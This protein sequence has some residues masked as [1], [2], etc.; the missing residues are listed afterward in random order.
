MRKA[1]F[2]TLALAAISLDAAA[3]DT[4]VVR[5]LVVDSPIGA[6]SLGTM[7]VTA[8]G[9][10]GDS[11]GY[12]ADIASP[13]NP[14]DVALCVL[15]ERRTAFAPSC[16]ANESRD[17]ATIIEAGSGASGGATQCGGF[18]LK[19]ERYEEVSLLLTESPCGCLQGIQIIHNAGVPVIYPVRG[20]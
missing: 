10:D 4:G 5:R 16:I 19:G 8:L 15:R 12:L 17:V 3:L 2:L 9:V 13:A 1:V 18:N 11:C 7:V 6:L 14:N 20:E